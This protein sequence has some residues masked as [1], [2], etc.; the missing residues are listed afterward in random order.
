MQACLYWCLCAWGG[1][2]GTVRKQRVSGSPSQRVGRLMDQNRT[3]CSLPCLHVAAAQA[4]LPGLVGVAS[5][6]ARGGETL[7]LHS[8][9]AIQISSCLRVTRRRMMRSTSTSSSTSD[10]V[11]CLKAQAVTHQTRAD[12]LADTTS[13]RFGCLTWL[14]LASSSYTLVTRGA[15]RHG[16]AVGT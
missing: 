3:P 7:A 11:W 9:A 5:A 14:F 13:W 15:E 6:T 16:Q 10:A 4:R 1:A 2:L 12:K 8:A